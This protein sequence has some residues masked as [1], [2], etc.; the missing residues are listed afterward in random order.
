MCA[1]CRGVSLHSH[2]QICWGCLKTRCCPLTLHHFLICMGSQLTRFLDA[3]HDL[4][5]LLLRDWRVTSSSWWCCHCIAFDVCKWMCLLINAALLLLHV[6]NAFILHHKWFSSLCKLMIC[7][8]FLHKRKSWFLVVLMLLVWQL[9]FLYVFRSVSKA[10]GPP[11]KCSTKKQVCVSLS[12]L[13]FITWGTKLPFM[14]VFWVKILRSSIVNVCHVSTEEDQIKDEGK[15]CVEKEINTDP[16]LG[17][18]Y[19]GKL[20]PHYPLVM[21]KHTRIQMVELL[22]YKTGCQALLHHLSYRQSL[23]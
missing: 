2:D 12:L 23:D 21:K 13:S 16:W 14:Y 9:E 15:N 7:C 11:I 5:S 6:G 18:R 1:V 17:Y 4:L 8:L 3:R 19:T 22:N 20:R 10:A